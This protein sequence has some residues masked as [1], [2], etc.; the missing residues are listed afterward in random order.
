MSNTET[1]EEIR[2]GKQSEVYVTQCTVSLMLYI[3]EG[4]SKGGEVDSKFTF[5]E[6]D[7][8]VCVCVCVC[9]CLGSVSVSVCL[10]LCSVF[11]LFTI[12]LYFLS[13]LQYVC[14]F[15]PSQC[16]TSQQPMPRFRSRGLHLQ[17]W[18]HLQAC[19]KMPP[20]TD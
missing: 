18:L 19:R 6:L 7:L 4:D 5:S 15:F 13:F 9:L 16:T 14:S 1:T 2:D 11:F 12:C 3:G 20:R 8:S 10:S 17:A